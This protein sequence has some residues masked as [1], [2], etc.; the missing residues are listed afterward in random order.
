MTLLYKNYK[1]KNVVA[2]ALLI[3]W[4]AA[5]LIASPAYATEWTIETVD[6][7][8]YFKNE[9]L[10]KVFKLFVCKSCVF[11][12]C[13]KGIRIQSFVVGDSYTASSIGHAD[14]FA[15]CNDLK[16][17]L[18]ESPYRSFGGDIGKEHFRL[19]PLPDKQLTPLSL[20][21]SYGGKL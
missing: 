3:F 20:L 6:P 1:L 8:K 19:E 13:F 2:A 9:K 16:T 10:K 21:L 14:M 4:S 12:D 15:S 18:A 7:P 11:N 5:L 17:S